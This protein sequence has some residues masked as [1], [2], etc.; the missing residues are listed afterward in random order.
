MAENHQE[1]RLEVPSDIPLDHANN[2]PD[3]LPFIASGRPV[4]KKRL[5][6]KLLDRLPTSTAS[7]LPLADLPISESQE[8]PTSP[9]HHHPSYVWKSVWRC[10]R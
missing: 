1:D 9:D 3:V 8:L 7:S 2:L 5:T 4:R 6:W 10:R